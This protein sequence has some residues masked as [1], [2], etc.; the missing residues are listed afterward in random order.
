[1]CGRGNRWG[2][3]QPPVTVK[4]ITTILIVA[5]IL[6]FFFPLTR[7]RRRGFCHFLSSDDTLNS[8]S[9]ILSWSNSGRMASQIDAMCD[10]NFVK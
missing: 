9:I 6:T 5:G 7:G 3:H 4:A 10:L 2:P 1:M 8:K